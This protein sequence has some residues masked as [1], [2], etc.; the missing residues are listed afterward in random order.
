MGIEQSW[1]PIHR[2]SKAGRQPAMH[3]FL[4]PY[5]CLSN[6]IV[7]V[8]HTA[9]IWMPIHL[10]RPR[11]RTTTCSAVLPIFYRQYT[12]Q[13]NNP[14]VGENETASNK[15]HFKRLTDLESLSTAPVAVLNKHRFTKRLN[16]HA[17][18]VYGNVRYT[19]YIPPKLRHAQFKIIKSSYCSVFLSSG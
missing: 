9:S 5:T 17:S 15:C 14:A 6:P 3:H 8:E 2:S 7:G 12:W 13:S 10:L 19:C 1:V 18:H 4:Q 11:G 16:I